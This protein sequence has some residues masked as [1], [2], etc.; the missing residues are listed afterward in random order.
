MKRIIIILAFIITLASCQSN[1]T[2]R[3]L[4]GKWAYSGSS[5]CYIMFGKEHKCGI[6]QMRGFSVVDEMAHYEVNGKNVTV[7]YDD[8][9]TTTL[10]L[11][12]NGRLYAGDG[13]EY[14][15]TEDF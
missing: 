1:N 12:E 4:Y 2:E 14:I 3:K 5:I 13:S 15:K 6:V 10:R 9:R 7:R 11:S 8:G